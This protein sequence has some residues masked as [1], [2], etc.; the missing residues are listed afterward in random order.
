MEW[1]G[2]KIRGL[3]MTAFLITVACVFVL[4]LALVGIAAWVE[5]D[6]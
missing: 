1:A 2:H 4:A 3:V 6:D 5:D